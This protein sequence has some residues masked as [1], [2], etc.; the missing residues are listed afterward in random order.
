MAA[1]LETLKP[2]VDELSPEE[3]EELKEY[4]DHLDDNEPLLSR[5]EEWLALWIP[6]LDRRAAALDADP[7]SGIPQDVVMKQLK[8]KYG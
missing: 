1:T 6:E 5:D 8:E 3:R 7:S 2:L 4:L